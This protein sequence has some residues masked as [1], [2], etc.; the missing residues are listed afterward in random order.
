MDVAEGWASAAVQSQADLSIFHPASPSASSLVDVSVLVLAITGGI[1]CVVGGVL[2]YCIARFRV[3][4]PDPAEPA[5]VYGSLP[6]EVAWIA[7]PI[8]IVFILILVTTRTLWEVEVEPP[9]PHPDD[10]ALFVTV[11]GR[12]WWWEFQYQHYNGQTV[13]FTTAN[14][15]HIPVSENGR[16]HHVYL[17][18]KSA[19]VCHSF[20]VPR[21][22]GK[23]DL[24]PGRVNTMWFEA[25]EPG[26]YLGQCAEY[27]GTQ[28]AG[29]LL[30]VIAEPVEQ[31]E[32][33]LAREQQPAAT[34][35]DTAAGRELFLSLSCVNCHAVQGTV[36]RG[37]YA[38]NLTHLMSRETLASGVLPNSK[39]NLRRWVHNPQ[40]IKPGCL[41]PAFG[42]S[43]AQL[44]TLVNYLETLR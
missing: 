9:A 30:R 14:E 11:V 26:T 28:H 15:L 6:I 24:I 42:L 37:M 5:Q 4:T 10:G 2:V 25:T 36:A 44:D 38:P 33:W 32:R 31:F 17:S 21:L 3:A 19:D 39:E 23:T 1:L 41:M 22:A 20:W 27:C 18:L 35:A 34:D 40:E 43:E 29:M 13:K 7:G 12:Q 8:M 16:P